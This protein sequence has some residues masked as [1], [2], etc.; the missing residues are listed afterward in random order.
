M[1]NKMPQV[2]L[3]T[4][5]ITNKDE[6]M[7][8]VP[9][10]LEAGYKHIDTAQLY[11]NEE[12][13]GE[14]LKNSKFKREDY[15]ITTKVWTNNFRYH[16]YES[17]KHS[18]KKLQTT[19]I[20]AMLLHAMVDPKDV[21]IAYG[22]LIKAREEGLVRTIG[23]SNFSIEMLELIKKEFNEYPAYNQI[24]SSV[25]QR[26]TELEEF[27]KKNDITLM[28]YSSIRPYYNPNKF[29]P[30]SSL[31]DDEKKIIDKI[32]KE[33]NTTPALVLLRWSYNHGYVILP[34][35]ANADRVK[36]NF[37]VTELNLTKENMKELDS[38]NVYDYQVWMNEMEKWKRGI[39]TD[40]KYK[41]GVR[42]SEESD[43]A[44]LNK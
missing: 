6:I 9:A 4:W 35:S 7:Q 21:I 24:L 20:D 31:T 8:V 17:V 18:L 37:K 43:K 39:P 10:A 27:C 32:A 26:V 28:G 12:F 44:F 29:F 23:V 30:E 13:I 5:Q 34:K 14:A 40:E 25:K 41:L 38:L 1:I 42:I 36:S 3:G 11:F 33:H 16:T 19:Y 15:W 2:A 22:E